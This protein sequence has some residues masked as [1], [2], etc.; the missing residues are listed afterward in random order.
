MQHRI[1]RWLLGLSSALL[2]CAF[3]ASCTNTTTPEPTP[4]LPEPT[5]LTITQLGV[6]SLESTTFGVSSSATFS[7]SPESL[8]IK[9]GNAF[10]SLMDTCSITAANDAA[11]AFPG[12]TPKD[13]TPLDAGEVLVVRDGTTPYLELTKDPSDTQFTYT[14]SAE[15]EL[16]ETPLTLSIPGKDFPAFADKPFETVPTFELTAPTNVTS[17][18]ATTEFTWTGTSENAVIR[19]D[20]SQSEPELT[21]TCFAKDDGAYQFSEATKTELATK[22]FVSGQLSTILS[23]RLAGRYEIQ[24]EAALLLLTTQKIKQF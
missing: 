13:A 4:T 21:I 19:L 15:G 3:L 9:E 23:G 16:P 1:R 8:D 24:G 12:S 11:P 6:V 5:P 14:S 18:T 10:T 7:K 20:V 2:S 17:I 22:G